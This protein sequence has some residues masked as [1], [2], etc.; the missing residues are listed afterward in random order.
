MLSLPALAAPSYLGGRR[1]ERPWRPGDIRLTPLWRRL[2]RRHGLTLDWR[3]CLTPP[4]K[5][6]GQPALA[7]Y[8]NRLRDGVYNELS[9][10]RPLFVLGGDHAN[11]M[12]VWDAA[13]A[14]VGERRFGLLWIDAHLDCHTFMTTPS[15]NV[16]GMPLAALLGLA[17]PP[18]AALMP[19][20]CRLRPEALC[21]FGVRSYERAEQ[22]A[23]ARL[24]V[25]VI[26]AARVRRDG[27]DGALDGALDHLERHCEH[28]G[29]SIDLDAIHPR[30]A[31]AVATPVVGGLNGPALCQALCRRVDPDRCRIL[32]IAEFYPSL[33][34][35]GR[36]Q[37]LLADLVGAWWWSRGGRRRGWA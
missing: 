31:P 28:Y 7:E 14:A 23:M 12:A 25:R 18:L 29:I 37:R 35:A 1:P 16:H 11:A 5:A 24:K 33:D 19:G 3:G 32:E 13:L 30:Q 4:D 20:R 36:T 9:S 22:E 10:G 26:Q 15:G 17:D 6:S 34:R 21:L 8:L 2:R 27:I